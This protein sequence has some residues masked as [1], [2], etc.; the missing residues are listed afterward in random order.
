MLGTDTSYPVALALGLLA[1]ATHD[2]IVRRYLEDRTRP[3]STLHLQQ[4]APHPCFVPHTRAHAL[5]RAAWLLSHAPDKRAITI[6]AQVRELD[7][8]KAIVLG[9]DMGALPLGVWGKW[10]RKD[11]AMQILLPDT[12]LPTS[13]RERAVLTASHRVVEQ[14]LVRAHGST[15]QLEPELGEWLFGEKA[16]AYYTASPD[17]LR[18][19]AAF[20]EALDAP[21]VWSTT[22]N[23][24]PI[25]ALS[26]SLYL[27]DL[28]RH[29]ELTHYE[30]A[31][32]A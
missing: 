25:L 31:G 7:A 26:P 11:H 27:G 10:K 17:A 21:A 1:Y 22:N 30:D 18:E 8:P 32:C 5:R 23:E 24:Q 16:L 2:S 19:I 3:T 14:G 20:L 12:P 6:L 9:I 13:A 15:K 28:P 4:A 29:D